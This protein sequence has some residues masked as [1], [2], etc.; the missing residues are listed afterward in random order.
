MS[1]GKDKSRFW[2]VSNEDAEYT[3]HWIRKFILSNKLGVVPQIPSQ[4]MDRLQGMWVGRHSDDIKDR[5]YRM[6]WQETEKELR[7]EQ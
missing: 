3:K 7:D 1:D 5:E 4:D 2:S 6:L